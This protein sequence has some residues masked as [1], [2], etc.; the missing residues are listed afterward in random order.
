MHIAVMKQYRGGTVEDKDTHQNE[1]QLRV[2]LFVKRKVGQ[3][4]P[5]AVNN[6][7]CIMIK[8]AFAFFVAKYITPGRG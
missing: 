7:K 1:Q 6:A 5:S 2:V 3:L 4:A 8:Q